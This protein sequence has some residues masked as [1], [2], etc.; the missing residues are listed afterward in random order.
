[1]LALCIWA[2]TCNCRCGA[3]FLVLLFFQQAGEIY[4]GWVQVR[5]LSV[6]RW[7]L[8]LCVVH[9]HKAKTTKTKEGIPIKYPYFT[10]VTLFGFFRDFGYLAY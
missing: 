2:L 10:M 9:A 7:S 8:E 6:F 4:R 3:F 5:L 1:M